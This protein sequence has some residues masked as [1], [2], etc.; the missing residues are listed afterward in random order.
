MSDLTPVDRLNLP[1]QLRSVF[2]DKVIDILSSVGGPVRFVGGCVRDTILNKEVRDIDIATQEE[3]GN[4]M[5]LL[6][7]ADIKVIPSGF[8]HGTVT[9]ISKGQVLE[10]TSL[11]KDIQTDGR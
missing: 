8:T 5:R 6:E 3:P 2:V 10:I 4:V 11:R 9:A 7:S 1:D